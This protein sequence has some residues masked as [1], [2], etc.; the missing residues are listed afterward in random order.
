[1]TDKPASVTLLTPLQVYE[2]YLPLL[3][4]SLILLD[5]RTSME[6]ITDGVIKGATRIPMYE[7]NTR[8][9]TEV[10]LTTPV[11]VYCAHGVRSNAVAAAMIRAGYETIYDLQGGIDLWSRSGLPVVR[12][13]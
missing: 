12:E 1:M 13:A 4:E 11:I 7:L 8:L 5:V 2:E 9:L 6:W 3:G 10:P